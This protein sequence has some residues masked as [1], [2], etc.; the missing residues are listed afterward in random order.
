MAYRVVF[1]RLRGEARAH[2]SAA[3]VLGETLEIE[4]RLIGPLGLDEARRAQIVDAITAAV[5]TA[6]RGSCS[7]CRLTCLSDS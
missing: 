3:A 4:I 1:E 5:E 6:G 7:L 2:P